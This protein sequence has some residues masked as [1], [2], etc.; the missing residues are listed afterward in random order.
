MKTSKRI[1]SFFSFAFSCQL[2]VHANTPPAPTLNEFN[3]N[4]KDFSI[5]TLQPIN[6]ASFSLMHD[7]VN[8]E[9][10]EKDE[11]ARI[12]TQREIAYVR[13]GQDLSAGEINAVKKRLPRVRNCIENIVS[14]RL[15]Y[16]HLPNIS[17]IASGG[18]Y[19]ATIATLGLTKGLQN[20]DMLDAIMYMA[21]L[22]GST[23]FLG[24]WMAQNI[25]L[26]LLQPLLQ[27]QIAT[28]LLTTPLSLEAVYR[29]LYKKIKHEQDTSL[30]DIW[31]IL[32]ANAFMRNLTPG[33][34][35]IYLSELAVNLETGNFPVPIFTSIGTF[36]ENYAWFEYSPFEIG[37]H[38]LNAFIPTKAFN[39]TFENGVATSVD[40]E[41]TF[42]YLMGIFGSA[43]SVNARDLIRIFKDNFTSTALASTLEKIANV[44]HVG[45][46]R[47]TA[48]KIRNFTYGMRS[49][50]MRNEKHLTLMDGGIGFNL[51]LPPMLRRDVDIYIFC[52]ASMGGKIGDELKKAIDY[53]QKN[54]HK[55]PRIDY[56]KLDEQRVSIFMDS[57][58]MTIPIVVYVPNELDYPT[59]KFEYTPTEFA[60]LSTH[61][62]K[63]I[64]DNQD[65]LFE[66]VK[67]KVKHLQKMHRS[68]SWNT[69]SEEKPAP[70]TA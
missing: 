39:S 28:H 34:R 43:F 12:S 58:D 7:I 57:H 19:R 2:L 36:Y 1:T 68:L 23:W 46:W 49:Q 24:N 5:E 42:G 29:T 31:G 51:P 32:L 67:I 59:S 9:A 62:S 22:S 38:E 14:E 25:P 61:M 11:D 26:K 63:A 64:E 21:T 30:V 47:A 54:G 6:N 4:F 69:H 41:Q 8:F 70:A 27:D 66:A 40:S 33:G 52:D 35:K 20:I 3:P 16:K 50:A 17:V 45:G 65:A 60:R 48:A 10:L 55:F 56:T 44:T 37:S 18:G 53:A 13:E 15:S